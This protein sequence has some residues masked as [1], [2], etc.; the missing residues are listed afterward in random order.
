MVSFRPV[1][2]AVV[3]LALL[4][5]ACGESR[6][7]WMWTESNS[8]GCDGV[9]CGPNGIDVRGVGVDF[10]RAAD[11][12]PGHLIVRREDRVVH[13]ADALPVDGRLRFPDFHVD[14]I[15]P[16]LATEPGHLNE[17]GIEIELRG[18]KEPTRFRATLTDADRIDG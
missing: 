2:T 1:R 14:G 8:F 16:G 17:V 6:R 3:P 9:V 5:A 15:T 7:R 18:G 13:E 12:L 11:A 10:G 4:L